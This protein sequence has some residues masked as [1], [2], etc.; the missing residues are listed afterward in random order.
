MPNSTGIKKEKEQKKQ[1]E[2]ERKNIYI[3]KIQHIHQKAF[4]AQLNS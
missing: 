3:N 4:R 2:K 1:K